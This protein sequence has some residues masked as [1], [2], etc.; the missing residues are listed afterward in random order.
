MM[1]AH[2]FE[3]QLDETEVH[4]YTWYVHARTVQEATGKAQDGD[5]KLVSSRFLHSTDEECRV[6]T[7]FSIPPGPAPTMKELVESIAAS[8]R[9]L[10]LSWKPAS[11]SHSPTAPSPPLL[12]RPL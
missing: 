3:V 8:R 2:E 10:I 6:H 1:E 7:A 12:P 9:A 11:G 5:G 4:R